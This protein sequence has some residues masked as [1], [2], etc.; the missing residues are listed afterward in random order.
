MIF[1][2]A[3]ACI[4]LLYFFGFKVIYV[5][6]GVLAVL[7]AAAILS[8]RRAAPAP[9]KRGDRFEFDSGSGPGR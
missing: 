7:Y 1:I 2:A 8:A 9:E 3:M 6:G 4:V 5:V